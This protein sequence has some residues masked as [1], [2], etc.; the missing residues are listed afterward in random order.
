MIDINDLKMGDEIAWGES[1]PNLGVVTKIYTIVPE[2]YI[3]WADGSTDIYHEDDFE[4]FHKTGDNYYLLCRLMKQM[5]RRD[6]DAK[7][8]T[9]PHTVHTREIKKE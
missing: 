4:N 7:N 5:K 6:E 1:Y 9:G 3:L 2:I 8:R